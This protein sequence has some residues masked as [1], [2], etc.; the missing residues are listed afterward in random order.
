VQ[1]ATHE[2]WFIFIE[3]EEFNSC[4][5]IIIEDMYKKIVTKDGKKCTRHVNLQGCLHVNLKLL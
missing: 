2:Q 1:N 3:S 4:I 5:T